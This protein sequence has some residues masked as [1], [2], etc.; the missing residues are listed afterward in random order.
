[1]SGRQKTEKSKQNTLHRVHCND[2][3]SVTYHKV[4]K[5]AVD[6]GAEDYD[7]HSSV[8]WET[9]HDMFECC[10][11]KSIVMRRTHTFSEW[12]GPEVRFFPPK[13]SR[14]KPEWFYKLPYQ[15]Q[16]LLEEIYRSLDADNR[17]L[18]L[19][20]ARTVLDLLIVDKVGDIGSFAEKLK[21]LQ[22]E[23][24]LSKRNREILDAA[25][26]AGHAAAHRGYSPDREGVNAVMD[27]VENLL[28]ATYVLGRVAEQIKKATPARPKKKTGA[29][30]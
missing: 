16:T 11:C 24:Y 9:R 15:F 27:I 26:D 2:C 8:W 5:T 23:G 13:V 18:P 29:S 7:E 14:H 20:G 4:L 30:T 6:S 12:D 28:H 19:I 1:M 21:R 10:G 3:R 25:L 17:T 22:E